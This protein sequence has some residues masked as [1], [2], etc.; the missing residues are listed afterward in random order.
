MTR[1]GRLWTGVTILLVL[2][3]NYAMIGVPLARKGASIK[4]K[5]KAILIKQ[6]KSGDVFKRSEDEYILELFRKEK[7]SIDRKMVILNCIGLTLA[8]FIASWTIFGL[9]I[10]R[11]K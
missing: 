9:I 1:K 8:I 7:L 5:S 2:A 3:I 6:V 10:Y 4:D 11:G